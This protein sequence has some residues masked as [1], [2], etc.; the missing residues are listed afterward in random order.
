MPRQNKKALR[1]QRGKKRVF[2][3]K[4]TRQILEKNFTK[5]GVLLLERTGVIVCPAWVT[6]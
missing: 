6:A 2:W 1:H 4:K 5:T 3:V